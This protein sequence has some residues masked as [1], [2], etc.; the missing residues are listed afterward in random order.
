[1]KHRRRVIFGGTALVGVALVLLI[2]FVAQGAGQFA[3]AAFQAQ[4]NS[5]ETTIPNFWGPLQTA[6]DGQKERYAEGVLNGEQGI[7]LV[8]YFDKARM[9]QTNANRPVTNGLLTVE[10]K[11]GQ[12]QLGDASF[13]PHNPSF[14]GI[15]GDQD[16]PGPTYATLNDPTNLP[17]RVAQRAGS[18]DLGYDV[19]TQKVVRVAATADP[20]MAFATYQGDPGGRFGQNVPKAFWD[21]MQSLPAPGWLVTMGYPISPAFATN[22]KVNGA[23]TTVF[24]QA[25]ERRVLTYTP[26][27]PQAFKVE[28]GNIGRHYYRWRYE[29]SPVAVIP[30]TATPAASPTPTT[31]AD[32]TPPKFTGAPHVEYLTAH[33]FALTWTTNEPASSEVKFGTSANY[34]SINDKQKALFVTE[35]LVVVNGLQPSTIYHYRI[36]S[37]DPASNLAVDDQDR[38]VTLPAANIT[39]P[40]IT[41]ITK[42]KTTATTFTV[43]WKTDVDS[44]SRIEYGRNN[45]YDRFRKGDGDAPGKDHAATAISLD[46]NSVYT[47]RIVS[48]VPGS[49]PPIAAASDEAPTN[50]TDNLVQT[51]A[52]VAGLKISDLRADQDNAGQPTTVSFST[53]RPASV[54]IEIGRTS[55]LGG[56]FIYGPMADYPYPFTRS[57]HSI[58]LSLPAGTWYYR[59]AVYDEQGMGTSEVKSFTVT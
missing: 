10:L 55:S 7:R 54:I 20:A 45:V 40:A 22:V 29:P 47:F 59:V 13:E 24:V 12:L 11:S 21:F 39:V 15:A 28:F 30:S 58:T 51:K 46:P 23:D 3:S 41:G 49:N 36:Q 31:M 9:E 4:W 34:E 35:H 52:E 18:V 57:L 1:M 56:G 42:S 44:S 14:I 38:T 26:T 6:R 43:T 50:Y 2:P 8:Q 48:I 33:S 27:N 32:T 37:R 25:F 17:E 16:T 5:V 53:D 19:A